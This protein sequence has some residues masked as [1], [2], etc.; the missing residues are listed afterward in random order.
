MRNMGS[1]VRKLQ[2]RATGTTEPVK[3]V[4][5]IQFRDWP[6][7]GLP[8][9]RDDFTQFIQYLLALSSSLQDQGGGGILV[10]CFGAAV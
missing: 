7:G 5:H 4:T 9:D 2:L 10:H 1:I 6:D 8:A 3:R